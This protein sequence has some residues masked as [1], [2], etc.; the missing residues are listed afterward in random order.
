MRPRVLLAD[1][2]PGMM[3]ALVNLIEPAYEIV[4]RITD[5]AQVIEAV[6]RLRPDV[7]V[8]DVNMPGLNG[9]EVCRRTVQAFPTVAVIVLSADSD[10]A[11]ASAA[12]EAG[13]SAF[14]AKLSAAEELPAALAGL[15][16]QR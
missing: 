12:R 9:I 6:A 8:V 16:R 4:G 5:G 11:L 10:A 13:S 14:I 2:H 3:T 7:L 15:R 1:D